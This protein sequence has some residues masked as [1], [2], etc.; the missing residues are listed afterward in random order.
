M[1][2]SRTFHQTGA[3]GEGHIGGPTVIARDEFSLHHLKKGD[4]YLL[5]AI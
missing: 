2:S 5:W 4:F 3:A 1:G